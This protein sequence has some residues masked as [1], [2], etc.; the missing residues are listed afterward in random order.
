[1]HFARGILRSREFVETKC[2]EVPRHAGTLEK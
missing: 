2:P 1:M